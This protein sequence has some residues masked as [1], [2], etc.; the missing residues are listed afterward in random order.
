MKDSSAS[1]WAN[2]FVWAM[3]TQDATGSYLTWETFHLTVIEAYKG[4]A[5]I[6]ITQAKMEKLCQGKSA[7]TEYFTVLDSLNKTVVYNEVTLIHL[8]KC[9]ID[10][11]VV[12][13]VYRHSSL[14]LT[15]KDWKV[16]V[17]EHNGLNRTFRV[18]EGSLQDGGNAVS[19][20]KMHTLYSPSLHSNSNTAS[21]KLN[22][23]T[24]KRFYKNR[25]YYK[26]TST[27][28]YILHSCYI[29]QFKPQNV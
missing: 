2:N 19:A 23:V 27:P 24:R 4:C 1:Q 14:P 29:P 20:P 6:E 8:L 9:S 11:K 13:E 15:Y 28:T 25:D 26:T 7:T 10:E 12:K 21:N 17:I 16:Q 5:Q 18:M 22:T 3:Q